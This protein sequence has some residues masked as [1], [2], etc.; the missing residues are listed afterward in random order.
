M[1]R[2]RAHPAPTARVQHPGSAHGSSRRCAATTRCSRRPGSALLPQQMSR[3]RSNRNAA[4]T[5]ATP[6][7]S[8]RAGAFGARLPTKYRS[9]VAEISGATWD[10]LDDVYE[11]LDVRSRAT[12]GSSELK[13]E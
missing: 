11:L 5:C 13:F 4:G 8:V 12:S 9:D 10:D 7:I 1:H 2:P 3:C 6:E